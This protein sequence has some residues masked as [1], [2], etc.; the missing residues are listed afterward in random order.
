MSSQH[1]A[2]KF[3]WK[4]K[5]HV[6]G[7][8]IGT[9][10]PSQS[11]IAADAKTLMN[12]ATESKFH[13]SMIKQGVTDYQMLSIQTDISSVSKP[14]Y[15]L[16]ADFW[17][18]GMYSE[19][20]GSTTIEYMDVGPIIAL[21]AYAVVAVI[22]YLAANPVIIIA[23]LAF[24]IAIAGALALSAAVTNI[25]AGTSEMIQ[26]LGANTN[27]TIITVCGLAVAAV[28]TAVFIIVILPGGTDKAKGFF[29]SIKERL[30]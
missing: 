17:N 11:Q 21:A 26:Q 9:A 29:N 14:T 15:E 25:E 2:T 12:N 8:L 24:I 20:T 3:Q 1:L 4:L 13:E 6:T 27:T 19:V 16:R 10:P 28:L 30:A 18:S 5:V 7:T 22:A 23:G